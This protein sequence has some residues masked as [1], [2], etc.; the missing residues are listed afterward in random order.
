MKNV[1]REQSRR[2]MKQIDINSSGN[3]DSE[4]SD[5]SEEAKAGKGEMNGRRREKDK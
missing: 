1:M 4:G 3:E 5:S 2:S